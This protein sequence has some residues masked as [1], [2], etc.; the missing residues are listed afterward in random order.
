MANDFYNNFLLTD[1]RNIILSEFKINHYIF[2]SIILI[3][4]KSSIYFLSIDKKNSLT[5]LSNSI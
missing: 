5:I 4:F 3:L 2:N 1:E